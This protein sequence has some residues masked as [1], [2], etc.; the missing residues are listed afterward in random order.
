MLACVAG[1]ICC[2]SCEENGAE[3]ITGLVFC[4]TR[5]A[6]FVAHFSDFTKPYL[7]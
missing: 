3:A 7:V 5:W 6:G 4:S 1:K 2:T